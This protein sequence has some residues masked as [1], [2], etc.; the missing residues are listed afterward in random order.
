MVNTNIFIF[1]SQVPSGPLVVSS[2]TELCSQ[3][4][5][6]VLHCRISYKWVY[7][8]FPLCPNFDSACWSAPVCVSWLLDYTA[9]GHSLNLLYN[10][11]A[12]SVFPNRS[13]IQYLVSPYSFLSHYYY[14]RFLV[15]KTA[16]C[17]GNSCLSVFPDSSRTL[18]WPSNAVTLLNSPKLNIIFPEKPLPLPIF[19]ILVDKN[20]QCTCHS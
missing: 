10:C 13:Y 16:P 2:P 9:A 12:K 7:S 6:F 3:N 4:C 8:K 17:C 1:L 20:S 11:M 18:S 14:F 5:R 19:L 15:L